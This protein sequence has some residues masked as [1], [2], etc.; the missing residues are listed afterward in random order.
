[1]AAVTKNTAENE[2]D[3]ISITALKDFDQICVRMI[4]A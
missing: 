4:L 1:M 2:N 3:N